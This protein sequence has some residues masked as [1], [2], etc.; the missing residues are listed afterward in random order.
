MP[1][2]VS[3]LEQGRDALCGINDL[4]VSITAGNLHQVDPGNLYALLDLVR[5]R[6]DAACLAIEAEQQ[7]R[8]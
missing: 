5:D 7:R 4:L 1:D 6:L 2:P 8:D 3:S